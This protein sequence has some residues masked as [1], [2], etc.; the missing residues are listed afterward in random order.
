[1]GDGQP[2]Q[3]LWPYIE[4]DLVRKAGAH[5]YLRGG[6]VDA[7]ALPLPLC[8]A[9]VTRGV[10]YL[11]HFLSMPSNM[12]STAGETDTH[13]AHICSAPTLCGAQRDDSTTALAT[14]FRQSCNVT[15]LLPNCLL[16]VLGFL[17]KSCSLLSSTSPT[18]PS[19][20]P[21]LAN[22]P[23]SFFMHLKK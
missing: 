22:T 3:N 15:S 5:R 23:L 7:Q 12:F 2:C 17:R 16:S 1:M 4:H 20:H 14:S 18:P 9:S 11:P 19:T 10:C 8:V 6:L 13:S 21:Q